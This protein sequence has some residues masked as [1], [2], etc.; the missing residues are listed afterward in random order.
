M[1]APATTLHA[2]LHLA[3]PR[4]ASARPCTRFGRSVLCATVDPFSFVADVN[5]RCYGKPLSSI[6]DGCGTMVPRGKTATGRRLRSVLVAS[7][8]ALLAL[9]VGNIVVSAN[10]I[11]QHL[12]RRAERATAPEVSTSHFRELDETTARTVLAR[13]HRDVPDYPRSAAKHRFYSVVHLGGQILAL[14]G[15][16]SLLAA[17]GLTYREGRRLAKRH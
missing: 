6:R 15:A 11:D 16:V 7:G 17:A 14:A 2:A 9:G 13:L 5:A 12:R 10:K 4:P 8:F 1:E 3:K